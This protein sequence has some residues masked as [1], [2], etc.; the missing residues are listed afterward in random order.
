ML[1]AKWSLIEA[2][3]KAATAAAEFEVSAE[4]YDRPITEA[5]W[6]KEHRY[7]DGEYDARWYA[8]MGARDRF[9]SRLAASIEDELKAFAAVAY[10]AGMEA[11]S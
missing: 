2:I 6:L 5:P 9:H 8:V 11:R 1:H 7:G 10:M 3:Y 4:N